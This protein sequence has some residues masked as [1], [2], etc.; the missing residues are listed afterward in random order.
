MTDTDSKTGSEEEEQELKERIC[1]KCHE[2]KTETW[3]YGKKHTPTNNC[4]SCRA[5]KA[6]YMSRTRKEDASIA[7]VPYVKK[8]QK[9]KKDFLEVL[10]ITMEQLAKLIGDLDKIDKSKMETIEKKMVNLIKA[11]AK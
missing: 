1:A 5:A 6:E 10:G 3:T 8:M 4:K 11:I 2:T 7:G 9:D